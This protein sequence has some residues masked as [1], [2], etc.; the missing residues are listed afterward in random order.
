ME[1]LQ[2]CVDDVLASMTA[3][4]TDE[5]VKRYGRLFQVF[6]RFYTVLSTEPQRLRQ[7]L[8]QAQ[9]EIGNLADPLF[10]PDRAAMLAAIESVAAK[11]RRPKMQL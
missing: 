1:D 11:P 2:E 9:Q 6:Y 3:A 8:T 10:P 7:E 4:D 5:K